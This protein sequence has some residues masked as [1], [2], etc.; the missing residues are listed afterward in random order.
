MWQQ[1]SAVLLVFG[2]LFGTL[3]LL[4]RKGIARFTGVLGSG[5]GGQR[6]M[7][8]IEK[9]PLGPQHAL[10][11]VDV[12]NSLLLIGISPQGCSKIEAFAASGTPR[13][14]SLSGA[15]RGDQP[16]GQ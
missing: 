11:L 15:A 5:A 13:E 3:V 4:R 2:L 14:Q 7:Q 8:I 16:A 6:Q 1:I 9:L 10:L 12:R